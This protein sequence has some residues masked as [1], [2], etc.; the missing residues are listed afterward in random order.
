MTTHGDDSLPP[1]GDPEQASAA[2]FRAPSTLV[3]AGPGAGKTAT[4]VKRVRHLLSELSVPRDA[5][6]ALVFG[7][8]AAAELRGRTSNLLP[9]DSVVTMHAFALGAIRRHPAGYG[10]PPRVDVMDG[11][12]LGGWV[13]DCLSAVTSGQPWRWTHPVPPWEVMARADER[14]LGPTDP[15]GW[16]LGLDPA[17]ADMMAACAAELG[18]RVSATGRLPMSA[19]IP[20]VVRRTASDASYRRA[21]VGRWRHVLVDEYQDVDPSQA[22]LLG[23]LAE[24][25]AHVWAVGD[26]DQCIYVF[27]SADVRRVTGFGDAHPGAEI[28][29][30]RRNYRS[31]ASIVEVAS[32]LISHNSQRSGKPRQVADP[33]GCGR[34]GPERFP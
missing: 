22:A 14:L 28:H 32:N 20:M 9:E 6:L 29:A 3:L 5:V 1:D 12:A 4:L 8:D 10:L 16:G 7:K 11:D 26:E 30:L 31:G 21:E 2:A 33:G 18:R 27:R 23:H 13:R 24:E 34:G 15:L 19:L 25:G 17:H